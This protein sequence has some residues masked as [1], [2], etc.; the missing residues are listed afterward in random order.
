MKSLRFL[1]V[2]AVLAVSP[3][4]LGQDLKLGESFVGDFTIDSVSTNDGVNYHLTAS[5]EAGPYAV[6]TVIGYLPTNLGSKIWVNSQG[7][8]GLRAVKMS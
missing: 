5:G 6:S 1:M 2:V 8:A 7:T 3:L 4:S